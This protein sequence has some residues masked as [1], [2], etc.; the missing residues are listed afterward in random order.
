MRA[1][2]VEFRRP[3][4]IPKWA[5]AV[6]IAGSGTLLG[7]QVWQVVKLERA[8]GNVRAEVKG[9]EAQIE[10]AREQRKQRE[11]RALQA[12][13]TPEAR[14]LARIASFPLDEVLTNVES[15][16]TE[17][18]RLTL[19]DV[20]AS[21]GVVRIECEYNNTEALLTYV[22]KLNQTGK[23]APWQITQMRAIN[24]D[25]SGAGMAIL[26]SRIAEPRR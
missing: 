24:K 6:L 16:R 22:A 19:L 14:M 8:L 26:I 11:D 25:N 1:V 2:H 17:G 12:D 4:Q 7:W 5:A 10:A 20:S 9:I 23:V 21:D 3:R 15:S 18:I 13:Q